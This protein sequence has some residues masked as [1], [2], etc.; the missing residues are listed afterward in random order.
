MKYALIALMSLGFFTGCATSGKYDNMVRTWVGSSES[1][2]IAGWGVPQATHV[3]PSGR[4]S[5]QYTKTSTTTR[6]VEGTLFTPAMDVKDEYWCRTVFFIENDRVQNYSW[7]GN[8]CV[9]RE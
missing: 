5:F 3:D 8:N 9:R 4:K 1:E 6:K 2:L 7:D